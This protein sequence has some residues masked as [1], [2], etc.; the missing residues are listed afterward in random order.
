MTY[1]CL[2][3]NVEMKENFGTYDSSWDDKSVKIHSVKV[4]TCPECKKQ[5]FSNEE[6]A[7][8]QGITFAI[9]N[10]EVENKPTE[11]YLKR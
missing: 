10:S 6:F 11:V 3:C 7:M 9:A 8:V 5:N 2:K 4:L 1:R